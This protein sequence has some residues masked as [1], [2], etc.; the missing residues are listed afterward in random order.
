MFDRTSVND[1]NE[2]VKP[3]SSLIT[4][5]LLLLIL[6]WSAIFAFADDIQEGLDTY[7]LGDLE[8]KVSYFMVFALHE[9]ALFKRGLVQLNISGQQLLMRSKETA[10]RYGEKL[11]NATQD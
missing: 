5:T 1:K 9:Q 4:Q 6:L 2:K 11:Q 3:R 8:P 7:D 10:S